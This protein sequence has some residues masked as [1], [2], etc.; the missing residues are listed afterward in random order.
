MTLALEQH[1]NNST[2]IY[3]MKTMETWIRTA[4]GVVY[5][6]ALFHRSLSYL[7]PSC[8]SFDYTTQNDTQ[9]I[10]NWQLTIVFRHASAFCFE[11]AAKVQRRKKDNVTFVWHCRW[12]DRWNSFMKLFSCAAYKKKIFFRSQLYCSRVGFLFWKRREVQWK[13][14]IIL[15][16]FASILLKLI[17]L[18]RLQKNIILEDK[19]LC[20]ARVGFL[21]WKRREVQ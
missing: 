20:F 19:V 7:L 4:F 6:R 14:L 17:F 16:P 5:K 11:S 12:F 15:L 2:F 10:D 13:D 21:F 18:R 1:L 8:D 9:A 3:P